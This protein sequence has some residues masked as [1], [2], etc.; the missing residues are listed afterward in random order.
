MKN[1]IIISILGILL[2]QQLFYTNAVKAEVAVFSY[3]N[4]R[5]RP[6]TLNESID[7]TVTGV[8]S[9]GCQFNVNIRAK[10]EWVKTGGYFDTPPYAWGGDDFYQIDETEGYV[11]PNTGLA[12]PDR[13]PRI[14]D[15]SYTCVQPTYTLDTTWLPS[16]VQVVSE[17]TDDGTGTTVSVGKA[18]TLQLD[19]SA[20]VGSTFD[21]PFRFTSNC[22]MYRRDG[23]EILELWNVEPLTHHC[24]ERAK[25]DIN[26]RSAQRIYTVTVGSS[27]CTALPTAGPTSIRTPT[28]SKT[29]MP[30]PTPEPLAKG[31]GW[32]K[33]KDA[34][35]HRQGTFIDDLSP[36]MTTYD[37]E[38]TTD[39]Y[40]LIGNAGVLT[41]NSK[42]IE[43]GSNTEYPSKR[44]WER[45]LFADDNSFLNDLSTFL[46][47]VESEKNVQIIT[48]PSQVQSDSI[49]I[50]KANTTLNN[51]NANRIP[52]NA[53]N[54][55]LIIQGDLTLADMPGN[56]DIF[57]QQKR[58]TAIIA[59]GAMN[60]HSDFV[61]L[62]GIFMARNIDLGYNPPTSGTM[63]P[64]PL[65]ISGNIITSQ[66]VNNIKRNRTDDDTKPTLFIVFK[67]QMYMDLL[68]SLSLILRES[69]QVQ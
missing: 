40:P 30:T 61:E 2:V 43:V 21:L 15:Y 10:G 29:P 1:N 54:Y 50:I 59:T 7:A 24:Q 66:P 36:D 31:Q 26:P 13:N 25:I 22:T 9:A 46:S 53:R 47:Y 65:K 28:P 41:A 48:Q 3:K 19:P 67:P 38:D 23:D 57:N 63:H 11:D 51:Q 12:D 18:Y 68:P 64:K 55:I 8:T 62:N 17:Q 34:S 58:S 14:V 5:C 42:T 4:T 35:L 45:S 69:S 52:N 32:F 60:V 39:M 20:P 33:L 6:I 56:G 27:S 44:R 37:S 16:Y 49:N